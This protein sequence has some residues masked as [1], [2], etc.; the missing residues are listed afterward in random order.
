MERLLGD[1]AHDEAHDVAMMMAL[2][3]QNCEDSKRTEEG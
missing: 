1:N 2:L 3:K